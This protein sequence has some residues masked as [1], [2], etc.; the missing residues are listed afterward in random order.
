MNSQDLGTSEIVDLNDLLSVALDRAAAAA[1]LTVRGDFSTAMEQ[2]HELHAAVLLERGFRNDAIPSEPPKALKSKKSTTPSTSQRKLKERTTNEYLDR[3]QLHL[4]QTVPLLES[5]RLS[6][7]IEQSIRYRHLKQIAHCKSADERH[8]LHALFFDKLQLVDRLLQ[9]TKV[10]IESLDDLHK[11]QT[12]FKRLSPDERYRSY[13]G[14]PRT[15]EE[16]NRFEVLRNEAFRQLV[17]FLGEQPG[18]VRTLIVVKVAQIYQTLFGQNFS[19]HPLKESD[20]GKR[21]D[22]MRYAINPSARFARSLITHLN[23]EGEFGNEEWQRINAIGNAWD[24]TRKKKSSQRLE[25]YRIE[26]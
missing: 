2:L 8:S 21:P 9:D 12:E 10:L 16:I 15:A 19:I 1:D 20:R 3:L 4:R 6:S 24:D 7:I 23:A 18:S 14:T 13:L 26:S 17:P 22:D 5:A 11:I 25:R